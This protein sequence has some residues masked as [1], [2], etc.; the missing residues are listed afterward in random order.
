MALVQKKK[1]HPFQRMS[2]SERRYPLLPELPDVIQAFLYLGL[3]IVHF[4][5]AI[6]GA[7]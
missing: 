1:A 3:A 4:F 5:K 2:L 7:E 6:S